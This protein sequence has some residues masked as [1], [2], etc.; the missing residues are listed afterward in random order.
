[1]KKELD[2]VGIYPFVRSTSREVLVIYKKT[3]SKNN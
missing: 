3:R 1:M 2:I